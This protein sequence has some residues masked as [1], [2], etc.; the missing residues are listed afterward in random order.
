MGRD[1]TEGASK[2]AQK[3]LARR[4][5]GGCQ[6][7]GAVTA[8]EAGACGQ[9]DSGWAVGLAPRGASDAFLPVGLRRKSE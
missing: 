1:A 5:E 3:R 8:M 4:L 2:G 6:R 7:L 9:G